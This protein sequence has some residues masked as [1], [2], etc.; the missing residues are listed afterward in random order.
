MEYKVGKNKDG[1]KINGCNSGQ[2]HKRMWPWFKWVTMAH[3]PI[4]F[5]E[6]NWCANSYYLEH[7]LLQ[8]PGDFV[9][10]GQRDWTKLFSPTFKKTTFDQKKGHCSIGTMQDRE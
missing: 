5:I 6:P 9:F 3:C 8:A 1:C 10:M 4:L 2:D 7:A